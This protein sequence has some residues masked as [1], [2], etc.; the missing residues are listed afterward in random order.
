MRAARFKEVSAR[1]SVRALLALLAVV[2]ALTGPAEIAPAVVPETAVSVE[3]A[4]PGCGDEDDGLAGHSAPSAL[5][6]T[7][8]EPGRP[9]GVRLLRTP[10]RERVPVTPRPV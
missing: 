9:T 5:R 7:G 8:A 10:A 4:S 6:P 3:T 1:P 2:A